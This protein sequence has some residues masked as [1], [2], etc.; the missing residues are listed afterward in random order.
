MKADIAYFRKQLDAS[1]LDRWSGFTMSVH[2]ADALVSEI[3][4]LRATLASFDRLGRRWCE[5][6]DAEVCVLARAAQRAEAEA[7]Q[8]RAQ[9]VLD[10]EA[11]ARAWD[12]S[13]DRERAAVVAY[14]L[15]PGTGCDNAALAE[16]IGLGEHR[17]GGMH[18]RR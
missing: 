9:R 7:E 6:G 18:E 4:D 13:R 16:A 10:N 11:L 14:L 17:C 2:E 12:E 15:A 3:E 5:C 1:R 8:L